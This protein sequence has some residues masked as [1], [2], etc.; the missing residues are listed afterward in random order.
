M[1]SYLLASIT[2]IIVYSGFLQTLD[3]AETLA[4]NFPYEW[5]PKEQSICRPLPRPTYRPED[6]YADSTWPTV[7]KGSSRFG[8]SN[9]AGGS[10]SSSLFQQ[11]SDNY[12]RATDE[13]LDSTYQLMFEMKRLKNERSDHPNRI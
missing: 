1:F 3:D 11:T 10:S 9:D 5:D 8:R 7:V 13:L 6:A 12:Q 4:A 2:N